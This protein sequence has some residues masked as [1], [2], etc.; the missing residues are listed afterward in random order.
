[1][2]KK[3]IVIALGHDALGTTLPEQQQAIKKTAKAVADFIRD[4]YQ[5]VITHSN[6]PQVGM[7]HT[8]MNEFCRIYPEYTKTPMSVCSAMSQGYIGYDLQNA[9]RTELLG[10]GI[11]KTVSTILTQ[12]EVDP[13]DE[14]FY[15]PTKIIGRIMNEQEAEEEE[16]KG[17]HTVKVEGGYRRIVAAPK[18][19]NIVEID[20]I[21]ALS[22]ADQVV[23][24]CGGGGIPV[25]A[26]GH[27][28]KGASAV[29]EKDLAAGRLAQ[30]LDADRLV[31]LTSVDK[32]CVNYGKE[33]QEELDVL[34]VEKARELLGKGEFENG[35]IKPKIEAAVDFIGESAI[36]SVLITK[37]NKESSSITGGMG[38]LIKK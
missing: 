7:I 32:V 6:G 4:D 31:I 36:K 14:A 23:I 11:Y 2:K 12:V 34:S 28:L 38:T 10:R 20:A 29:I 8:A 37:L 1:M 33:D 3:K 19:G 30:L 9:I 26:Q 24:A 17:N 16:K 21:K 22:D 27:K 35:T 5:V 18:P 15:H 13:Y 25:L